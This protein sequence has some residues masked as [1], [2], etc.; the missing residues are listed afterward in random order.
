MGSVKKGGLAMP[1]ARN[2]LTLREVS[3]LT[4][5]PLGTLRWMRSRGEGPPTWK[6]GRRVVAYEA[7]VLQWMD[8]EYERTRPRAAQ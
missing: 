5:I 7:E 1:G 8:G 4:R 2:I 3:D 6:L